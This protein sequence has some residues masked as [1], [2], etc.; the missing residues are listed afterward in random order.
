MQRTVAIGT[1]EDE[2]FEI[3][4]AEASNRNRYKM[5]GLYNLQGMKISRG[6]TTCMTNYETLAAPVLALIL[7]LRNYDQYLLTP[8]P[9]L[10]L[11]S[12]RS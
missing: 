2:I 7:K 9:I 3:N 4:L 10:G 12:P 8:M 6:H 1:K 11:R 5:M